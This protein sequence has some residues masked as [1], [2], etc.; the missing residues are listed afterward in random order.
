MTEPFVPTKPLTVGIDIKS[1]EC[2]LALAPTRAVARE[3]GVDVDWL[4]LVTSPPRPAPTGD[5][6]DARHKRH[7]VAYRA[8]DLARYARAQG[9][10]IRE[11]DRAP[12]ST[13]AGMAMLAARSH[14]DAALH[15]FLDRVFERYWKM[16]LD[17]ED[18]TAIR[19]LL[20]EV[21]V[22][23]FDPDSDPCREAFAALGASLA[24]AGLFN[25][26]AYLVEDELFQG[27]AHLPMI[28]WIL[29]GR[30][31]PGPI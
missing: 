12:D 20:G 5:D 1:P 26:P 24:A 23:D 7:R 19:A 27:R 4:P 8:M 17:L 25:A 10:T 28:R 3:L 15:G 22:A 18:A 2:Y 11:P 31:G 21:G 9:L 14:S 6:R 13:V 30:A 29:T 16:E